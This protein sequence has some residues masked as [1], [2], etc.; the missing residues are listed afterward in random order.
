MSRQIRQFRTFF[1]E[2]QCGKVVRSWSSQGRRCWMSKPK[3]QMISGSR[4]LSGLYDIAVFTMVK[5]C[6]LVFHGFCAK[7]RMTPL[8]CDLFSRDGVL[9]VPALGFQMHA[10]HLP[11]LE[12]DKHLD[13]TPQCQIGVTATCGDGQRTP[14]QHWPHSSTTT[15]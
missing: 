3:S 1:L 6:T 4:K 15:N 12:N 11:A 5:S 9:S 7:N 14:C 10:R 8:S 2:V 13:K